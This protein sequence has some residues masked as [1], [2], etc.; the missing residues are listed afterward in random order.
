MFT[1]FSFYWMLI[2]AFKNTRALLNPANNPFLFNAP[3]T[4]PHL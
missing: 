2:T 4:L 1:A 3:P